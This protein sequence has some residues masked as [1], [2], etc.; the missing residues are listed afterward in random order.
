MPDGLLLSELAA[1]L[2]VVLIDLTLAGDNAVV[3]G[4]AVTGLPT[5]QRRLAI[6]IG[7]GGAA[8]LRIGFGA[9]TLQLLQ[10][11]GLLLAGGLLL[12]WVC[13]KMY[14]E[15]RRPAHGVH[16]KGPASL[17]DAIVQIVLADISMSLDNVL[18]VA[19][20]AEGHL[21]VLATGLALSVVLMGVAANLVARLLERYRWIAWIG[22]LIVLFV[23]L[24]LIWDG[25]W[26]VA[27]HM[28]PAGG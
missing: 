22:L 4:L 26:D 2:Q 7:V 15:L 5:R 11:V 23:A 27:N 10:I 8:V 25:G 16:A 20:A 13:W 24:R 17:R 9:V 21:W 1:L 18:A 28:A 3:V 19:G 14:R 6:L 12:L